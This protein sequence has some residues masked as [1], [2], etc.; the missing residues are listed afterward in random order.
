MSISTLV[1]STSPKVLVVGTLGPLPTKLIKLIELKDIGV[2]KCD[3]THLSSHN[4]TEY[5]KVICLISFPESDFNSDLLLLERLKDS[6]KLIFIVNTCSEIESS[7]PEARN[8]A[9]SN[10]N[11]EKI[12]RLLSN[13]FSKSLVIGLENV[14]DSDNQVINFISQKLTLGKLLNPQQNYGFLFI[15]ELLPHLVKTLFLPKSLDKKIKIKAQDTDIN[16]LISE[17]IRIHSAKTSQNIVANELRLFTKPDTFF[18]HELVIKSLGLSDLAMKVYEEMGKQENRQM[19]KRE[20][21]KAGEQE[22]GVGKKVEIRKIQNLE[23]NPVS[24]QPSS[25]PLR[26]SSLVP[27]SQAAEVDESLKRVFSQEREEQKQEKTIQI[28]AETIKVKRKSRYKQLL[29]SM[30]LMFSGLILGSLFLLGFYFYSLMQIESELFKIIAADMDGETISEEEI[31]NLGKHSNLL[32]KQ[33]QAYSLLVPPGL[34]QKGSFISELSSQFVETNTQN[35]NFRQFLSYS[36]A[37]VLGQNT[38]SVS[39]QVSSQ[40]V[41]ESISQLIALLKNI[42]E[43]DLNSQKLEE[44]DKYRTQLENLAS[45]FSAYDQLKIISDEIFGTRGKK[46][47]AIILQNE[48]ELRPTGGYIS[49]IAILTFDRGLLIDSQVYNTYQLDSKLSGQVPPPADLTKLLG[50]KNWYLRD[51]NWDP[52][53]AKSASNITWFLE[54]QTSSNIDSVVA[55]N[56]LGLSKIIEAT[57]PLDLAEYNEVIT[58]K[59][60]AERMEFHSEVNLTGDSNKQEY[61]QVLLKKALEKTIGTT[62]AY[63]QLIEAINELFLQKMA[64]IYLKDPTSQNAVEQ[65]GWSGSL[66][67]P[68]CPGQLSQKDCVS[69]FSS[70]FDANVGVNKANFQLERQES[71]E[72]FLEI[73]RVRHQRTISLNNKSAT[74]S[75]P[76]GSYRSFLRAYLPDN[77]NNL[78]IEVAGKALGNQDLN[79]TNEPG[80]IVVGFLSDT[81]IKSSTNIVIK[82]QTPLPHQ[83]NFSYAY[84]SQKQIGVNQPLK[85]VKIHYPSGLKP[86]LIAPKAQIID[87][88]VIFGILGEDHFFGGVMFE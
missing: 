35:K 20:N 53:F 50:E 6:S 4:L 87:N 24:E 46:K 1:D 7:L 58:A 65:I 62:S 40:S 77:A 3:L 26:P 83:K 38:Q 60:L 16:K 70:F 17:L 76:Q 57:G 39:N 67:S 88:T 51:S 19:G 61:A 47:V 8:W 73:D 5:Y 78:S 56:L 36:L 12:F 22:N 54:R 81:P 63:P 59:N 10:Q 25:S 28:V 29:F 31:V 44:V 74:N 42:D 13:K 21:G 32:Q 41:Y 27:P 37:Q 11:Q 15:S 69:D 9:L 80:M 79:I 23:S 52:D 34:I 75:W 85:S 72:I 55:I 30:F 33:V 49:A 66:V 14:V 86:A 68:T 82:Y 18:H 64:V 71:H 84:F 2:D 48:Q 45:T 43:K